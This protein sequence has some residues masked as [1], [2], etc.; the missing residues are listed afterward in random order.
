MLY[1]SDAR[2]MHNGFV[3]EFGAIKAT[4]QKLGDDSGDGSKE[5]GEVL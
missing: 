3:E 4:A 1:S 5:F 2:T